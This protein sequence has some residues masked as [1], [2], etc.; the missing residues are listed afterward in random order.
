MTDTDT[1]VERMDGGRGDLWVY[2]VEFKKPTAMGPPKTVSRLFVA[3]DADAAV[4]MC[5]E[6]CDSIRISG[7]ETACDLSVTGV[8]RS[9]Q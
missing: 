2:R 8:G 3:D 7:V 6:A 1:E 5:K 4:A 9:S